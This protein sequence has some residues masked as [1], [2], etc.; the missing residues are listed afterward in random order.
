MTRLL[1]VLAAVL[2]YITGSEDFAFYA[3]AVPGLFIFVGVT[4]PAID[5]N[6]APINHSPLFR[7]DERGLPVALRALLNLAVDYLHPPPAR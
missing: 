2:P 3:N 6:K 7:V 5:P 4:D 1:L